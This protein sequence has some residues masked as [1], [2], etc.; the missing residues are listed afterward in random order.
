ML[1]SSA[2]A[3]ILQANSFLSGTEA[4]VLEYGEN[5]SS[6]GFVS[7]HPWTRCLEQHTHGSLSVL[8]LAYGGDW[9]EVWGHRGPSG[10]QS[11]VSERLTP[12]ILHSFFGKWKGNSAICMYFHHAYWFAVSLCHTVFEQGEET[13]PCFQTT[14]GDSSSSSLLFLKNPE[15]SEKIKCP[16]QTS[17]PHQEQVQPL[18]VCSSQN[19]QHLPS[20]YT[21]LLSF[22]PF[23]EHFQ[24][25]YSSSCSQLHYMNSSNASIKNPAPLHPL[26]SPSPK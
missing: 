5:E 16:H 19:E 18:S 3:A 11:T 23:Y 14:T 1:C 7:L 4:E 21:N 8:H 9:N 10:A 22:Q 15:I 6:A 24:L 12:W 13:H 20:S 2:R 26:L 17:T 25:I